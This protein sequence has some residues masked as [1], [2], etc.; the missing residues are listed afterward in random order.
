MLKPGGLLCIA[1]G[2]SQCMKHLPF[3]PFGFTLYNILAAKAVMEASGLQVLD[4]FQRD[5]TGH[6]NTGDVLQKRVNVIT[7]TV[8]QVVAGDSA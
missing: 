4:A 3:V 5:E 6:S 8:R 1:F 7:A 2:D